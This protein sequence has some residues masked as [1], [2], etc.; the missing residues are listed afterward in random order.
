LERSIA[1]LIFLV[2]DVYDP[3]KLTAFKCHHTGCLQSAAELSWLLA[4]ASG[5]ICPLK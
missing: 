1:S 3:P 2:V 5:T 4:Q